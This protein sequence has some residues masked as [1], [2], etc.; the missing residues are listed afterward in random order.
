M[1]SPR[2]PFHPEPRP[3][4]SLPGCGRVRQEFDQCRD[5]VFDGYAHFA[6]AVGGMAGQSR[7]APESF[8]NERRERCRSAV[9]LPDRHSSVHANGRGII[10]QQRLKLRQGLTRFLSEL[11]HCKRGLP[12]AD[13]VVARK[14]A[15]EELVK[16]RLR[17][18]ARAGVPRP[19][20][21]LRL[22]AGRRARPR[23]SA[24]MPA[25][26]SRPWRHRPALSASRASSR[27]SRPDATS[28]AI[29]H[30]GDP[31]SGGCS[32]VVL[33]ATRA[34]IMSELSG[35]GRWYAE[36]VSSSASII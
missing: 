16:R 29:C 33:C 14:R 10:A 28:R 24:A 17:N 5:H 34:L 9:D 26:S 3:P 2:S 4:R 30:S 11:P 18:S 8:K 31:A 19:P 1:V 20:S 22:A 15:S 36:R 6:Q 13:R 21:G 25:H 35:R 23:L 32:S 27:R 12:P 7:V